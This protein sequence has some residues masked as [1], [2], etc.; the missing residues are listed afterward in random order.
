ML[1]TNSNGV[2]TLAD[3]YAHIHFD[4]ADYQLAKVGLTASVIEEPKA[5]QLNLLAH[6]A[7]LAPDE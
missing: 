6:A 4:G 7:Q 3:S 5:I 2:S 1:P